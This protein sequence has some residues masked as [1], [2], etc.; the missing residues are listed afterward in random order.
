VVA[1]IQIKAGEEP[2]LD[3][4]ALSNCILD[5]DPIDGQYEVEDGQEVIC[6]FLNELEGVLVPAILIKPCESTSTPQ[7]LGLCL[8]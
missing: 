3:H 5:V 8:P 1:K 2:A 6:L 4:E 7:Y